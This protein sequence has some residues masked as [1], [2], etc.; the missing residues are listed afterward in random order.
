MS[1]LRETVV[2]SLVA[3][4]VATTGCKRT[5]KGGDPTKVT[6]DSKADATRPLVDDNYRFELAWPGPGWKLMNQR[7][8]SQIVPDAIAG[9]VHGDTLA[10]IIVESAPGVPLD[11]Y[12]DALINKAAVASMRTE[13]R[14]HVTFAGT[15]AVR[16]I[17]TATIGGVT[18]RYVEVAF[19]HQGFGYQLLG[20][21]TPS[22]LSTTG[23]E[24]QPFF[25]A[26]E[27]RPGKV[28]GRPSTPVV[29]DARGVGWRVKHGVFESA[30]TGIRVK[31]T[32]PWRL[33]VGTTL[34]QSN[35]E[36]EVGVAH[37]DPEVYVMVLAERAP[38]PAL[39]SR[40]I[41]QLREPLGGVRGTPWTGTF[42]GKP[43]EFARITTSETL[44]FEYL[45]GVHFEGDVL[46]QILASY[47]AGDRERAMRVVQSGLDG[48]DFLPPAEAT[49]LAAELE[50]L[51]DTQAAVGLEHAVRGG[52]YRSFSGGWTWRK[53][54]SGWRISEGDKAR[55]FNPVS[56]LT[57]AEPRR[58]LYGLAISESDP[59][60]EEYHASALRN[61]SGKKQAP[62]T[63]LQLGGD[64]AY[65]TTVDTEKNGVVTTFRLTTASRAGHA[66]Q[67]LF[68]ATKDDMVQH[69]AAV[70][71]AIRGFAFDATPPVE[72]VA[73][74]YRDHRF[75]FSVDTPE[76]W[77]FVDET[78]ADTRAIQTWVTW[79][80]GS[81]AMFG[82]IALYTPLPDDQWF[83][84]FV[85]QAVRDNVGK[86][87]TG[88]ATR[89]EATLGGLPARQLSWTGL[90]AWVMAR[91]GMV[92][93]FLKT[94]RGPTP[95]AF[96]FLDN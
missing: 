79:K 54:T 31:V 27:L 18:Y 37:V 71:A 10:V 20:W 36:A 3:L 90:D 51:P 94:G 91:N 15:E 42:A 8:A 1:G 87:A 30:V 95:L 19:L 14:E 40:F 21:G 13:H 56:E 68:W 70:D 80:Q 48:F 16:F 23:M 84:D 33:L 53:P 12:A 9:A 50:Q 82:V 65:T 26:F 63:T 17:G 81:S 43:L 75:G 92:Y 35:K 67:L 61:L 72:R 64:V 55:E 77:D 11:A 4:T 45:H 34:E 88:T 74:Q 58:N 59:G 7:D 83:L 25:D 28:S 47:F 22:E 69:A 39:R 93:A 86:F 60:G 89:S 38:A 73:G 52:V 76:G 41:E 46:V 32:Q 29:T 78:P 24:L 6:V 44:A 49:A 96:R 2:I 5:R 57:L 62:T 66:V 85:E